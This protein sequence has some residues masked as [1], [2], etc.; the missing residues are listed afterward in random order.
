VTPD[1]LRYGVALALDMF[2]AQ[3]L[4]LTEYP[5]YKPLPL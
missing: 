5:F 2:G 3:P 4:D 1:Q